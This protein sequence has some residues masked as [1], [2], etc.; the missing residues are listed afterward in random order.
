MRHEHVLNTYRPEVQNWGAPPEGAVGPLVGASCLCE[1]HIILNKIWKQD[2]IILAG[3]FAWFKYFT[4]HLV[5]VLA[6]NYKQHILSPAKVSFLSVSQHT[7]N[8]NEVTLL[9]QL[10]FFS[11]CYADER[12][13]CT[14][15]FIFI[16]RSTI[17]YHFPFSIVRSGRQRFQERTTTNF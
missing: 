3:N 16:Y 6:P 5:P 14:L 2:K 11:Y 10:V 13:Y 4:Y 15:G 8:T 9:S 17:P 7:T 1:G 12:N